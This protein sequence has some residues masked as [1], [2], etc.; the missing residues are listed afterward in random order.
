[1]NYC[2]DFSIRVEDELIRLLNERI[3]STGCSEEDITYEIES[4]LYQVAL[5]TVLAAD[6]SKTLASGNV[7]IGE[8]ILI[9]DCDT[10]VVN[11]IFFLFFC[12]S[13]NPLIY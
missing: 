2:L 8:I 12:I 11:Y 9:V 6:G 10:R 4:E 5:D 13:V 3:E 7:R 1:M